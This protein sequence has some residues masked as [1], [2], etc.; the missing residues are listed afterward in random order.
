[1]RAQHGVPDFNVR[2]GV[3]TGR[4]LLGG[5]V[6]ADGS[7][8]GATVNVAARMEQSAPPGRLRISHDSWRHVRG[9]FEFVEQAP[10]SVKGVAEPLRSYL[11][12]RVVPAALRESPRGVEGVQT[13]MV[14]RDAELQLLQRSFDAAVAEQRARAVTV[15]GEAGLG[16]S[17]LLAEFQQSLDLSRCWLLLGRA[18]PRS[19]LQPYGVLRNMLQRHLHISEA[20]AP[21]FAR[22]KLVKA[23]S[24]LFADEGEAPVHLL[25]HMIGLDFSSSPHG[26]DLLGDD[27]RFMHHLLERDGDL[28]LLSLT[29][30]RQTVFEAHADWGRDQDAA[31][32]DMAR[33]RRRQPAQA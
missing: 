1:M 22:H 25:G 29:L 6:D 33:W 8:R 21:D 11:V 3:H 5:G 18:H 14:G 24:P 10:I 28:P 7:I 12:E 30:T 4:V 2:A 32:D 9:I 15:V 27:A 31:D 26:R 23:L 19:A 20:D 17:R 16:K 13:R